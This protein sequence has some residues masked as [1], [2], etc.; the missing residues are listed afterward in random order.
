L[1]Q[2]AERIIRGF[3]VF[4]LPFVGCPGTKTRRLRSLTHQIN[5]G[6]AWSSFNSVASVMVLLLR[7]WAGADAA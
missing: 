5:G 4:R 7:V 6:A 2:V 1:G 3:E